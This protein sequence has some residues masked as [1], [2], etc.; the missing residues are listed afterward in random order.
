VKRIVLVMLL[1]V[2]GCGTTPGI[3]FKNPDTGEVVTACG[4]LIGL[5]S[6][7]TEAQQGCAE[8]YEA[9]GWTRVTPKGSGSSL[10]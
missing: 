9:K 4:P 2:T 10:D 1:A 5:L 6:A 3:A 8:A 7:T